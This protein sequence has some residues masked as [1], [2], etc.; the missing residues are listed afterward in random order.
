ML[1]EENLKS[2]LW[3]NNS[4]CNILLFSVRIPK[5]TVA[6]DEYN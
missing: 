6:V 3:D 4:F 2:P 5:K 1:S